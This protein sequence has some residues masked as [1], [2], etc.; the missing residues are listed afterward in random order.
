[1]DESKMS[2]VDLSSAKDKEDFAFM[3]SGAENDEFTALEWE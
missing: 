2:R 1:M 3:Q